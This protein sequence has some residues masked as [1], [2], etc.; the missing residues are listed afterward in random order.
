[1]SNI[2]YLSFGSNL[3]DRENNLVRGCEMVRAMEGFEHIIC[4]PIYISKAVEMDDDAPGFF[5]MVMMGKYE[6]TPF[7]LLSGLEKIEAKLGRT[8]KGKYIPRTIDIDILL[9]GNEVIDNHRLFIPHKKLTKRAFVLVPL[10]QLSP[11]LI[12]PVTQKRLSSYLDKSEAEDLI[13][14]KDYVHQ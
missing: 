13:L 12:H 8:D 11:D 7:E 2:V 3:G 10:I 4:S 6:Y 9:F 14:Y 1:M 5:N